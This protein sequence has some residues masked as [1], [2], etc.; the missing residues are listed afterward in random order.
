MTTQEELRSATIPDWCPGCGNH[1]ILMSV[2]G[3]I[4]DLGLD[5]KDVVLVSGIGC[6]AKTPHY[7][8]TYGFHAIH[9]RALPVASGI[10]LANHELTVLAHCGDG[11]CYGI[12]MGH[13]IH[14]MR[15]NVN[16]TVIVHNNQIYG[17]TTGQTS[18]TSDLGFKSKSTPGG[19]I[20][21]A[22][23]PLVLA[24]GAGGTFVARGFA[25]NPR[26]LKDLLAEG[27]KHEGSALID[28][29][30]PCVTF[31]HINTFA[32]FRERV[33]DLKE[34]GHDPTDRAVALEKAFEWGDRIPI[35]VIYRDD[36]RPLEDF[37]PALEHGPL[38]KQS[39]ERDIRPLL[40]RFI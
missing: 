9:G 24:I 28:V 6:S 7:V 29:L 32:W 33:Y 18:P 25:G 14:A 37:V 2:K 15:R 22:V 21:R 13:F 30:Q 26:H 36:R 10:R 27:I 5:P 8:K 20:E 4:A 11:D 3:A 17:L 35:G 40:E 19:S 34:A 12:G 23:M 16:I 1:A 31:N 38:V 39:L